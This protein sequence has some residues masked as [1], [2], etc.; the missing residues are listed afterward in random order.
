MIMVYSYKKEL[1]KEVRTI[2][3]KEPLSGWAEELHNFH[4]PRWD[5]LPDFDLYLDQMLQLLERYLK[6]F[7]TEEREPLVTASMVHNYVKLDL[8]P[9]PV[10]KRYTRK[11]MAF[12]IAITILKQVMTIPEIKKG[13]LYQASISGIK[14]AYE[15]F[16]EEQEYTLKKVSEE[17]IGEE[18]S[19]KPPHPEDEYLL[20]RNVVTAAAAKLAAEKIVTSL[21]SIEAAKMEKEKKKNE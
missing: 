8:I 16:C 6:V 20:V 18:T 7:K 9:K 13:I 21:P 1:Q 15:L 12:L 3:T 5:E 19:S 11:H 2:D 4:L 14:G 10:K 17:Y